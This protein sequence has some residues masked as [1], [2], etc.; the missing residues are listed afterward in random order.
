MHSPFLFAYITKGL[1]NSTHIDLKKVTLLRKELSRNHSKIQVTDFGA[2]SRIFNSN[3]RVVSKIATTAGISKKRGGL[4]ART[5]K[6]F[7]PTHILEI[8][9]SLGIATSYMALGAPKAN[10]TTLE[11]CPATAQIAK[12]N[13]EKLNLKNIEVKIGE[14]DQSL[15]QLHH[16]HAYDLIFFDGN[17]QKEATIRYF[18]KC[19]ELAHEKS[20]FIFDDIHWSKGM[21]AAWEKIKNHEKV[22]MSVDTYKWG[23][24]FFSKGREKQHFTIRI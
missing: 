9:T 22:S 3:K 16:N 18:K 17:H 24:V 2:G 6:Y 4:L 20:V 19:L 13:F 7:N 23:L 14:F 21:E 15:D 10:I 11:G 5:T 8:G 12:E 1:R